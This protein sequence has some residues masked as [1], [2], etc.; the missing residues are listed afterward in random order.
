MIVICNNVNFNAWLALRAA[1]WPNCPPEEHRAEMN[2]ILT[3]PHHAAFMIQA[4]DGAFIALAEVALRHDYV[5]G[6]ESS[7]VAFLEGIYTAGS[8]RRQGCASQLITQ[9]QLWAKQQG[10]SEL[11][12][13]TDIAN[14]GSQ[15][16]HAALGF[17]ETER[18]VFY[19][20]TLA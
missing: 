8:A 5:N 7:P 19:R 3:S 12:S 2:E 11:A 4:A 9:V 13:D 15:H 17:S 18:V 10:C 1:L 6:C 14:L 20:K 16:L